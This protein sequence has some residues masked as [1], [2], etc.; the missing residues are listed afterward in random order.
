MNSQT[1]PSQ[2][3]TDNST[4]R[5]LQE[6]Q[7]EAQRHRRIEEQL[8]ILSPSLS[9]ERLTGPEGPVLTRKALAAL[10]RLQEEGIPVDEAIIRA[11]R[12][13]GIETDQAAKPAS[14]LRNLFTQKS[15]QL[16]PVILAKLE[17][18]IDPAP[19]LVLSPF[20]P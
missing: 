13:A 10:Y 2:A 20:F 4:Q 11:S 9:T 5:R 12:L 8:R 6:T 17:A 19:D 1:V 14:F 15:G 18:G 7:R 3:N 16:T